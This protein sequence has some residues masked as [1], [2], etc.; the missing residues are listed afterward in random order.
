MLPPADLVEARAEAERKVRRQVTDREL[1]SY[2]MYPKVFVDFADHQRRHGDVSVLPTP[3][4]FYGL[5]RDQELFVE[6]ERGKTRDPLPRGRRGRR[7]GPAR[8]SSSSAAA[9]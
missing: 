4:F 6:I 1:A 2:L 9:R 8:S 3:V 7:A 5:R